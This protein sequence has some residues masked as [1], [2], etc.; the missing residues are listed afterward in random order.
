MSNSTSTLLTRSLHEVFGEIDPA[1]RRAVIEEIYTEDVV[2]YEPK[3]IYRGR[4]EIDR[5][6]G[7]IKATHPEFRYQLIAEP[8][9]LGNSAQ[10]DGYRDAPARRRLTREP[11]S[12]LPG[13]TGL[14]LSISF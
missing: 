6:A 2:F 13:T 8:E 7:V 14:P 12:S 11:I 10:A 1:R 9:E 4:D 5:I 3:G